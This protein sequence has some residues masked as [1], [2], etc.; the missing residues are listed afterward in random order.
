MGTASETRS[1]ALHEEQLLGGS[2]L[3][4][5]ADVEQNAIHAVASA[6]ELSSH[7]PR[8]DG[9]QGLDRSCEVG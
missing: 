3:G 2:E 1:Q 6:G 4:V 5:L 9:A 7:D 8:S